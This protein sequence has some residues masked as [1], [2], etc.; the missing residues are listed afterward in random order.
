MACHIMDAAYW[1]LQLDNPDWIE[2][3]STPVTKQAC[4]NASVVTYKFPKR[5]KFPALKY[6]WYDGGLRPALPEGLTEFPEGIVKNGTFIVGSEAVIVADT[7]A[8]SVRILPD[9]K[10]NELK[11]D[12]PPKTIRRIKGSHFQEW[13]NAI[14]ENRK[15]DSD[16]S[17]S[18]PFTEMVSLGNVALRAGTR[19]E[20]SGKKM[21]I[22]N[23]PEANKYLKKQYKPGWIL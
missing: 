13:T 22:T 3:S 12:L 4:P 17:Y 16:F 2:A 18:G 21:E 1:A 19:I 14:R 15:A 8:G 11:P 6:K 5:G 10:F 9:A 7:Y 20:Y 23:V